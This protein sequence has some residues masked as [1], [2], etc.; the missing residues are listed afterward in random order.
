VPQDGPAKG[1]DVGQQWDRMLDIW[2]ATVGYDRRTGRPL[3]QTLHALGLA[4]LVP[5]VW[6]PA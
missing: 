3:P 4:E 2:Y 1:Q 5:A 6:P